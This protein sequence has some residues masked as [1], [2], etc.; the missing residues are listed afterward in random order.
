RPAGLVIEGLSMQSGQAD[1]EEL[2]QRAGRGD[3]EARE[4]L[5]THHRQ[6]L[7]RMVAVRLDRRLAARVDPSDVVQETLDE[8]S[9]R[10]EDYLRDRAQPFY[11]GLRGLAGERIIDTPRQ[12]MSAPGRSVTLEDKDLDLPDAS[13]DQ[14]VR[15]L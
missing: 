10:L 3:R 6:R 2:L 12:H 1:T 15:R 14:L 8:A 9:K 4:E 7:K 11:G 5:L 13:A